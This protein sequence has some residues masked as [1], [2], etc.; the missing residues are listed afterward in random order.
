MISILLRMRFFC[1]LALALGATALTAQDI[2]FSQFA[3]APLNLNPALAGVFGGDMRFVGN[4][5]NQ[6]RQVPVPY[7]TLSASAESKVYWAK[8]KYDRYLTGSLLINYD[9]QGSIN[10]TSILVGI[11]IS[12]TLPL[13][14]STFLTLGATPA[15]GQ[16]SFSKN[17]LS[18]DAQWVDSVFDPLADARE[19]QLF[20]SDNLKYFD[21]SVGANLRV[22][23]SEKRSR[24]DLGGAVHHINRP[25]HDFWSVTLDNPGNVRLQDKLSLYAIGL[26]EIDDA[27]DLMGQGIFQQ[28]GAYREIVYGGGVRFH[29]DR[30]RYKEKALQIGVDYRHRYRDALVPHAELF[31]RTWQLGISYD[32]NFLSDADIVTN[33]RGGL[34]ISLI[35]R[36]YRL[37][38]ID[39]YLKCQIL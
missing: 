22:Q 36:I 3:N 25:Y 28:Q 26:L 19:T 11:P 30:D 33:G 27:F 35:Y 39:K 15:F 5:R 24:I 32:M 20:Q 16:R 18:F 14:Q 12:V 4:V 17:K 23:A 8:N 37:K 9:Q 31:L 38:K 10:L 1:A 34:E 7:S 21:L 6:W 2:H 29:L 13:A